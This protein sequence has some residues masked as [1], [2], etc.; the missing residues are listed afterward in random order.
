MVSLYRG[1]PQYMK[2]S[3]RQ[4]GN[5][6]YGLQIASGHTLKEN[7]KGLARPDTGQ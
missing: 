3:R 5:Y 1:S 2:L 7:P 4:K 6:E